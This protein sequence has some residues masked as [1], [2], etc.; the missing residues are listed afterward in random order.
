MAMAADRSLI[1]ERVPLAPLTTFGV[2]AMA[3]RFVEVDSLGTLQEAFRSPGIAS[4]R[5]LVLG[6][7]SNV[8]FT[9]DPEGTVLHNSIPGKELIKEEQGEVLIRV[10]GGEN[11]HRFVRYCVEQGYGGVENL[12]LIPGRVGAAPMQNIGAYGVELK[13]VFEEL[14]AFDLETGRVE[15]FRKAD[16]DFAYRSSVFKTVHKGRFLIMNVT[17]RLTLDP[18]FNISYGSLKEELERMGVG[19]LSLDAVSRAVIRIRQSKLPDPDEIG[20][21]GSFFKN[22]VISESKFEELKETDPELKGFPLEDGRYKIPAARLIEKMG[23]KGKRF[24]GHGVHDKQ[25]LVLVNHGGA[26]GSDIRGL[27]ERIQRSVQEAFGIELEPEV[28]IL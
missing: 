18:E 26:R 3:E 20:N 25:A 8:L 28:N 7:G 19:E 14:E 27:A 1:Q 13:E 22:P 16:C 6:G 24:D 9:R 17:L 12:S 15:R 11:W 23:W 2:P 5:K 21:A 10:G 4:D